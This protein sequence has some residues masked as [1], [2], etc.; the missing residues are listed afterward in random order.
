L[1][2]SVTSAIIRNMSSTPGGSPAQLI[3]TAGNAAV[4]FLDLQAEIL[5]N[6]H[7]ISGAR[8]VRSAGVLAKLAA[9][10]AL[11]AFLSSVPP[12]GAFAA[13]GACCACGRLR[14]PRSR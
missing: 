13:D 1:F 9:L 3:P 4:L 5:P 14:R 6:A 11:P 2:R 8:V 7:T 10:H 12:G